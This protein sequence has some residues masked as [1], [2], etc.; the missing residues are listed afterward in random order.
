[1]SSASA[2]WERAWFSALKSS[3]TSLAIVPADDGID[4][5][6]TAQA[7]AAAGQRHGARAVEIV[8]GGGTSLDN[9]EA[10]AGEV[11]AG[12]GRGSLVLVPVDGIAA[13]PA[14]I[15]LIRTCG[16]VLLVV[17]IGES[18]LTAARSVLETIGNV[19]VVGSLAIG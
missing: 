9:V 1:M 15:P 7:L 16:A 5:R 13:N 3:W 18:R 8:E 12:V 19:K 10:L 17:K 14:A 11:G 4:S 6:T 2:V